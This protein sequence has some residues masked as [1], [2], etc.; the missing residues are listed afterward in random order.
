MNKSVSNRIAKRFLDRQKIKNRVK[1][2]RNFLVV[3]FGFGVASVLLLLLG[4]FFPSHYYS[5]DENKQLIAAGFEASRSVPN[6]LLPQ[7]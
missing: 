5:L 1:E 4:Y 3:L 7:F 2:G 6:V